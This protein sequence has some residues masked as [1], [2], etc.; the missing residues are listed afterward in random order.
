MATTVSIVTTMGLPGNQQSTVTEDLYQHTTSGPKNQSFS[1][2]DYCLFS[3]ML[4]VSAFIG[5]YFAFIAK[6]KQNT[7]AEYLMG[8]KTM[9]VIPISM[10][11]V[12]SYISGITLLGMSAE[13]YT[14]GTQYST[15]LFGLLVASALGGTCFM[16]V[17]Y[18]LQLTTSYEYLEMRFDRKVRLLGSVLFLIGTFLYISIVIY[19]PALA[20]SQVT[21]VNV[22]HITPAVCLVCIFYTSLGGLKAVVW[23]DALQTIMMFGGMLVVIFIGTVSVGG[24]TEVWERNEKGGRLEFFN[25][26]PDPTI[27][28]TFWNTAIASIFAWTTHFSVNQAMVQRFLAMPTIRKANIVAFIFAI[29]VFTITS[30]SLYAGL[31]IYASYH[32]CDLIS[33]KEMVNQLVYAFPRYSSM[34]TG[35]N[36]MAGVMYED[37]IRPNLKV[38]FSEERA[39]CIM[40]VICIIIG[41]LCVCMVFVVERLGAVVQ[42]IGSLEGITCGP[43]LAIFVLGMFFPWANTTGTLA[44]GITALVVM[45]YISLGTQTA[46]ASGKI[47]FERKPVT[48]EGCTFLPESLVQ[49]IVNGS[50]PSE[51]SPVTEAYPV[52]DEPWPIFRISYT[53]YVL[54]GLVISLSVA[55]VVSFLTGPSKPEDLHIDLLSP[56]IRRFFAHRCKGG[57]WRNKRR[58]LENA[59]VIKEKDEIHDLLKK[60]K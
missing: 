2:F 37:F 57:E 4:A 21:G 7:T 34:S 25:L 33:S 14:Y 26:D 32:D 12:A 6:Q 18:K 13:V 45:G 46:I 54:M 51:A 29:G 56:A 52:D 39:S 49:S 30:I 35:L 38:K 50:L 1:A 53:L 43:T 59:D 10:S 8:G 47:T 16:P 27:R 42:M 44:G 9:G 48:L 19:L 15:I 36:S 41:V 31:L 24:V 17:I 22:H 55:L 58:S 60:C 40:K 20:F 3:G 28:H 11:L 23:A 5:V